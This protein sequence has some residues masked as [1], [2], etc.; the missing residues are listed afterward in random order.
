MKL[1]KTIDINFADGLCPVTFTLERQGS[2]DEFNSRY[3][4][5]AVTSTGFDLTQ[6]SY[7][8][9]RSIFDAN[10]RLRSEK[11]IL[12]EMNEILDSITDYA[13]KNLGRFI[14]KSLT[15]KKTLSDGEWQFFK[16]TDPFPTCSIKSKES[17]NPISWYYYDVFNTDSE[18]EVTF[19]R[20]ETGQLTAYAS[21]HALYDFKKLDQLAASERFQDQKF[22][23]FFYDE[24]N[25]LVLGQPASDQ[26]STMSGLFKKESK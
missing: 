12:K 9:F 15:V 26:S 14:I 3:Y 25:R 4:L 19:S 10:Q 13:S 11:S 8:A 20:T 5:D 1:T 17:G 16:E 22:A 23:F 21:E 7:G 18:I 2:K 24:V 6:A